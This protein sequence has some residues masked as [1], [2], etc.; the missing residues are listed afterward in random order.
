MPYIPTT[1]THMS[2]LTNSSG[3][4]ISGS[5][6]LYSYRF[7]VSGGTENPEGVKSLAAGP[8]VTATPGGGGFTITNSGVT[9]ISSTASVTATS[10]ATIPPFYPIGTLT[11][12]TAVNTPSATTSTPIF[13]RFV[14]NEGDV[15]FVLPANVP[16]SF[17]TIQTPTNNNYAELE[18]SFVPA[19]P[20]SA[21]SQ[22]VVTQNGTIPAGQGLNMQFFLT[23]SNAAIVPGSNC[24]NPLRISDT[25][26]FP[27]GSTRLLPS[28]TSLSTFPTATQFVSCY[29]PTPV[30]LWYLN[31]VVST[32]LPGVSFSINATS[33]TTIQG[34]LYA[35]SIRHIA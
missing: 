29:S 34:L 26:T 22:C 5:R 23:P 8:G 10:V 4:I 16:I 13:N 19:F 27:S 15:E 6:E 30:N 1:I 33:T 7:N 3:A 25:Q 35:N 21:L 31:C 18:F 11:T 2:P 14:F 17:L 32:A 28:S 12:L 20:E 24:Y 9:S